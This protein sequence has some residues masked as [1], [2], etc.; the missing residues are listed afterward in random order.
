M[1]Q[2]NYT[3]GSQQVKTDLKQSIEEAKENISHTVENITDELKETLDWRSWVQRYPTEFALGALAIGFWIG[4]NFTPSAAEARSSEARRDVSQ[5]PNILG[6]ML[7]GLLTKKTTEFIEG[8]GRSV[9]SGSGR[10]RAS[11]F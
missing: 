5:I 11:L 8:L 4:R 2:K 9:T 7:A 10:V 1:D 6:S 3:I